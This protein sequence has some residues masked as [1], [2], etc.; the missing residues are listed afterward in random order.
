MRAPAPTPI[1]IAPMLTPTAVHNTTITILAPPPTSATS[2]TATTT[3]IT[4]TTATTES[5]E[6]GQYDLANAD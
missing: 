2:T 6:M 3:T 5:L 1:P 4:A